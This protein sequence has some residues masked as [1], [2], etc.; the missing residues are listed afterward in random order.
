MSLIY[1]FESSDAGAPSLNNAAG[2]LIAMLDA[3]LITGYNT[4]SVTSITV[5]SGVATVVC[6]GHGFSNIYG[7]IVAISGAT[8][9]VLNIHTR[10][11]D[12][13]T[14]GFKFLCPGVADGAATGTL[15]AK[16]A[17]VG[18]TKPFSATNQAM[19]KRSDV[20]ASN[21][22]LRVDDTAVGQIARALMVQGATDLNT[23]Y[24]AVPTASQIAGGAGVTIYKAQASTTPTTWM[25]V[26]DGLLIFVFCST[27]ASAANYMPMVF[28]DFK[29]F[30]PND[31]LNCVLGA[32]VGGATSPVFESG[33]NGF[34]A[35]GYDGITIGTPMCLRFM[36]GT[37]GT[38]GSHP[39]YPS[40]VDGGLIVSPT[41]LIQE[42]GGSTQPIRGI[43]PGVAAPQGVIGGI[44]GALNGLILSG[45]RVTPTPTIGTSCTYVVAQ[46]MRNYYDTNSD[47]AALIDL[48]GPWR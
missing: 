33:S 47:R 3:C 42:G 36:G 38:N 29:S 30:K 15:V 21:C 19:Y 23:Y 9:A 4:K 11:T 8:P 7:K 13:I 14:N 39:S 5:A 24:N 31:T 20:R 25:V 43:F 18:W 17:P 12:V 40:A 45:V 34:I 37:F 22:M 32:S 26:S 44:T 27:Y 41:V 1:C 2:S 16:Y 10:I 35:G 48:T 28:G 46:M 6:A